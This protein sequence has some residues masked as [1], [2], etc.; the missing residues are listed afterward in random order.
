MR[1]PLTNLTV[2][3]SLV[4]ASSAVAQEYVGPVG[5]NPAGTPVDRNVADTGANAACTR[6]RW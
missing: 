3:L 6:T 1:L 5:G 4:F 2:A